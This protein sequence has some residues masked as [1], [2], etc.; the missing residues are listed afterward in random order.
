MDVEIQQQTQ[1]WLYAA[2]KVSILFEAK[3]K[4]NCN[5]FKWEKNSFFRLAYFWC[6]LAIIF[7]HLN[8]N[9]ANGARFCEKREKF[10]HFEKKMKKSPQKHN[11]FIKS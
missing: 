10:A 11:I 8:I 6:M 4:I 3:H 5:L 9:M 7:E 2:E 1:S